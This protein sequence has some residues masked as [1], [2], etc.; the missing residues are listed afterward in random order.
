MFM[1]VMIMMFDALGAKP[2]GEE[3]FFFGCIRDT[4]TEP[5]HHHPSSDVSKKRK[6]CDSEVHFE[7][8]TL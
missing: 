8:A 1:P 5:P 6:C 7:V 4:C 3:H 2:I